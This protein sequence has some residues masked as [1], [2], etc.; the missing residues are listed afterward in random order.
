MADDLKEEYDFLRHQHQQQFSHDRHL[1][2][3][4]HIPPT[5]SDPSV[6]PPP[7]PSHLHD[8]LIP[9]HQ[10]E[11]NSR[12]M[13]SL[14][15]EKVDVAYERR[16]GSADL[17]TAYYNSLQHQQQAMEDVAVA[18]AA[19]AAAFNQG[20]MSPP[21]PGDR[22]HSQPLPPPPAS[23]VHCP[24]P[25]HPPPPPSMPSQ[26]RDPAASAASATSSQISQPCNVP[27]QM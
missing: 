10:V 6:P 4:A 19:A 11:Q 3:T 21:P 17:D 26:Q 16:S 14:K 22:C 8:P 5:G 15:Q 1:G 9:Q 2:G 18:A 12:D 23:Q 24:P 13:R 25:P 20:R 7:P 27:M